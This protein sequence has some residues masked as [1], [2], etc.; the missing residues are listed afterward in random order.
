MRQV[1]VYD[2][3]MNYFSAV[4][5][6]ISQVDVSA[7]AQASDIMFRNVSNTVLVFG[8]GGSAAIA[9][10]FVCDYAKGI[11]TD[12]PYRA[13]A[14]SLCSNGPLITA[15]ANDFGYEHV[16]SEQV[17]YAATKTCGVAIAVSSSG[18]SI[19]VING[20]NTARKYGLETVALVGF[21]G[22]AVLKNKLADCI[23]HVKSDNYGVVEDTHMMVLHLLAQ[24]VRMTYAKSPSSIKL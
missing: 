15:I 5:S 19:N 10:H 20:L 24:T 9:D 21:D 4:R 14:V 8:N 22:G 2:H 11:N 23:V 17:K 3:Y 16:F 1:M 7:V 13:N 6:A 12:T 18:N